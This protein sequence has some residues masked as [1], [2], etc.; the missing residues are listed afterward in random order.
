[1]KTTE[2]CIRALSSE[3]S[4]YDAIVGIGITGNP[5]SI[6]SEGGDIDIFVYST[7]AITKEQKMG[8]YAAC[9]LLDSLELEKYDST[10]WGKIDFLEIRGIEACVMYFLAANVDRN[11]GEILDGERSTNESGYYPTGR[12]AM[13]M[14][15]FVLHEKGQYFATLQS[16]IKDYPPKLKEK[17][18]GNCLWALKEEE[19][20]DRGKARKDVLFFHMA[21][22]SAIDAIIQLLF[23]LNETY[24]PSRKRNERF[25][26]DFAIQPRDTYDRL[27]EIIKLSASPDTIDSAYDKIVMLKNEVMQLAH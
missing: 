11:I 26:R 19:N 4:R 9:G 25:I 10:D 6:E 24:M 2:D 18:I 5:A 8:A 1:M 16:R 14:N 27:L 15:I 17:I 12:L 13:L 20:L 22:E 23:A 21:V 7:E 3:L